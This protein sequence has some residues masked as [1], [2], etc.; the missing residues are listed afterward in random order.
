MQWDLTFKMCGQMFF[1]SVLG[2]ELVTY[3]V[4]ASP[5][6]GQAK[7]FFSFYIYYYIILY[8]YYYSKKIFF[9]ARMNAQWLIACASLTEDLS[10][11]PSTQDSLYL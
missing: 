7:V 4:N 11:S 1:C 5:G 2:I 8:T 3:L 6:Q 9:G 10:L